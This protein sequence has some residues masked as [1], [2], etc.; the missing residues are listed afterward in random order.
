VQHGLIRSLTYLA[1]GL[2]HS[3]YRLISVKRANFQTFWGSGKRLLYAPLSFFVP[4]VLELR[5]TGP[6]NGA[7]N[8][9]LVLENMRFSTNI[10]L[11]YGNDTR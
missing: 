7:S 8:A 10:S 1:N 5:L 6:F 9:D 11:Y 2:Q 4:T 3:Q